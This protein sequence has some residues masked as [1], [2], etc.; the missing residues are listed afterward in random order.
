M[1]THAKFEVIAK[2]IMCTRVRCVPVERERERERK[3]AVQADTGSAQSSTF[4]RC[5]LAA[6]GGAWGGFC[7]LLLSC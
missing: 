2:L 1:M 6:R 3:R 5:G 4:V 7:A